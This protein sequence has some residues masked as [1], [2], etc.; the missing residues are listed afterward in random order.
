VNSAA[1]A[2]TIL[3]S[4]LRAASHRDGILAPTAISLDITARVLDVAP[5][6]PSVFGD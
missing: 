2:V 3:K 5:F 1:E 6:V 4:V